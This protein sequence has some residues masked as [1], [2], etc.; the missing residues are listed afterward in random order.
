MNNSRCRG[1]CRLSTFLENAV[2][3]GKKRVE[4][5]QDVTGQ[6]AAAIPCFPA[7]V[8][9]HQTVFPLRYVRQGATGML[10]EKET[11]ASLARS[12]LTSLKRYTEPTMPEKVS[13]L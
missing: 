7:S 2:A 13:R 6:N 12:A 1:K 8:F 9:R 10:P 3:N 11:N 5:D 4:H